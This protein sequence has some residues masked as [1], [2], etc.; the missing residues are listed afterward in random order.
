MKDIIYFGRK[1]KISL[2]IL[3]LVMIFTILVYTS[4]TTINAIGYVV[5]ALAN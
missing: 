1:V 4:E 2:L 3:F 5:R